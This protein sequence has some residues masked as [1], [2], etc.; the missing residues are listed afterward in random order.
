MNIVHGA[1]KPAPFNYHS[2]H[3]AIL[4]ESVKGTK[5]LSELISPSLVNGRWRPPALSGRLRGVLKKE[6]AIR[7][8]E[9]P[10][11][12]KQK[13]VSPSYVKKDPFERVPK[14]HKFERERLARFEK[15]KQNLAKMPK[16][17]EDY[18]RQKR[19]ERSKDL[20]KGA[21][22]MFFHE[23]RKPKPFISGITDR[24]RLQKQ[25]RKEKFSSMA[26]MRQTP[27]VPE[28]ANDHDPRHRGRVIKKLLGKK[29]LPP[30]DPRNIEI[31]NKAEEFWQ[32]AIKKFRQEEMKRFH[33]LHGNK[34]ERVTGEIGVDELQEQYAAAER[35]RKANKPVKEKD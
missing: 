20:Y 4:C 34:Y 18:R 23:N 1:P 14:G 21:D 26:K 5:E 29:G 10:A 22:I 15:I 33:D 6:F 19:L 25:L 3:A 13:F 32:N 9:W 35:A 16:M 30:R 17:V 31:E 8:L 11:P 27:Y 28:Y 24:H 2:N 12:A 7:G